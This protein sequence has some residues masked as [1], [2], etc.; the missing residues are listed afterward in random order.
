IMHELGHNLNLRHGGFNNDNCKPNY[1]SVM[2]Y[3]KFPGA[4]FANPPLDYSRLGTREGVLNLNE[5]NPAEAGGIGG[6]IFGAGQEIAFGPG[7]AEIVA[8]NSPTIDWNRS[9]TAPT[10]VPAPVNLNSIAGNSGC[11]GSEEVAG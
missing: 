10:T 1:L 2:N 8:A 3:N 11:D 9:G 6:V 5:N 4:V 7:T